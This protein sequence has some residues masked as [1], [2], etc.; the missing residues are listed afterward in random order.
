MNDK[1]RIILFT[2]IVAIASGG[3]GFYFGDTFSFNPVKVGLSTLGDI[4]YDEQAE[5]E[6]NTKIGI[7]DAQLKEKESSLVALVQANNDLEDQVFSLK[8]EFTNAKYKTEDA[9]RENKENFE[10]INSNLRSAL[11][12][13]HTA[14]EDLFKL[15][16]LFATEKNLFQV[17]LDKANAYITVLEN[18]NK[19]LKAESALMRSIN[20]ALDKELDIMRE[21]IEDISGSRARHGPGLAA[22]VDPM[23]GYV[24]AMVVGWTISWS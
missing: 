1:V 7:L 2:V 5:A 10:A 24:F 12:G 3:L 17:E 21:R 20:V 4:A 18:A 9:L 15:N 8:R 6:F 13:N 11:T 23:N 22:G 14:Q 16:D 19:G